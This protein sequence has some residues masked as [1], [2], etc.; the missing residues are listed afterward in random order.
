[1]SRLY[2]D[3][4]VKTKTTP[5]L[6]TALTSGVLGF[7]VLS[8]RQM[9]LTRSATVGLSCDFLGHWQSL[10]WRL[11]CVLLFS[12][13]ETHQSVSPLTWKAD[14]LMERVLQISVIGI[15]NI[16]Q[17]QQVNN[18]IIYSC[19]PGA[20]WLA[21]SPHSLPPVLWLTGLFFFLFQVPFSAPASALT[22]QVSFT[23]TECSRRIYQ[24]WYTNVLYSLYQKKKRSFCALSAKSE[25]S[26]DACFP[27]SLNDSGSG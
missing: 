25:L 4:E 11:T 23:F 9:I 13:R 7:A 18:C 6:E 15:V 8:I 27:C 1:M 12:P 16:H 24:E 17:C 10:V 14:L 20:L 26:V 2:Y 21:G 22:L 5:S 3:S 19:N